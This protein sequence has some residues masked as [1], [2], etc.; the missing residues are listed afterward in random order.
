MLQTKFPAVSW[1]DT[2]LCKQALWFIYSR[3]RPPASNFRCD[4][5]KS[6]LASMIPVDHQY[7]GKP[8][9]L[10][11]RML[12]RFVDAEYKRMVHELQSL[13]RIKKEQ[14]MGNIA[15]FTSKISN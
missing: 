1:K 12:K 3:T 7:N 9:L 2:A 4:W 8:P 14:S 13:I 15:L 10:G 11:Y 6:M 5:F